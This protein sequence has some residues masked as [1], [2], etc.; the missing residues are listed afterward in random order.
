V[1]HR[2]APARV[3]RILELRQKRRTGWQ[4]AQRLGMPPSTV[5]AVLRREGLARLSML[6]PKPAIR[7]YE[8]ER[9]GE[10][11]HLDTKP[12]G[13]IGR[14]GH[15]IHGDRTTRV[16][17]IGWEYVHVA[18]DDASRLAYVE[19]RSDQ[20]GETAVAFFER[21]RRW[22]AKRRISI[23]RV[24]TDNGSCYVCRRFRQT[25]KR[26]EIRH[27]RTRSYRPQTNGKAER[28]IGT[29]LGG[30]AYARAYRTSNQ[31]T[32]ALP[33]WLRYYNEQRPHRS[34]GMRSPAQRL[35]RAS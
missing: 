35:R 24:L 23:E 11:V 34:L 18:I 8:R 6:E 30:W 9:P 2:T 20:K 26:H 16:R 10:L 15:R 25:L 28:F 33:K 1:R 17:G 5:H 19:V 14:I 21:A 13:R 27:L 4:I 3:R 32:Q 7:R 12:L 31:R 22:F 29:M